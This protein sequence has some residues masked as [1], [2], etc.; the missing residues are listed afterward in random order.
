MIRSK[1]FISYA[2]EDKAYME[3]F[4]VTLKPL[5]HEEVSVWIDKEQIAAGDYWRAKIEEGLQDCSAA[6]LLISHAFNV[7]SFIQDCELLYLKQ[8]HQKRRLPLFPVHIEETLAGL[9]W[10][11]EIEGLAFDTPLK[12]LAED[13]LNS[14]VVDICH[15]IVSQLGQ[16]VK[17]PANETENIIQKVSQALVNRKEL[18]IGPYQAGGEYSIVC[19]GKHCGNTA[20]IKIFVDHAMDKHVPDYQKAIQDRMLL[21]NHC[22]IKVLDLVEAN[23][24]NSQYQVLI[25]KFSDEPTLASV[26][27]QGPFPIDLVITLIRRA[28]VALHELHHLNSKYNKF[29]VLSTRNVYLDQQNQRLRFSAFGLSSFLSVHARWQDYFA[30]FEDTTVYFTPEQMEGGEY[31]EKSDQYMLGQLAFELLEGKFPV[32]IRFPA[33]VLKK[34]RFSRNPEEFVKGTWTTR[35]PQLAKTIFRMLHPDPKKRWAT[36]SEV[37]E[38]LDSL[39]SESLSIARNSYE[40]KLQGI[41]LKLKDNARFFE[42]FYNNFFHLSPTSRTKFQHIGRGQEARLMQAMVD[43]FFFIRTNQGE[44]EDTPLSRYMEAHRN[45]GITKA[46]IA[47]FVKSFNLTLRELEFAGEHEFIADAWDVVLREV[48]EHLESTWIS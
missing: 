3:R 44:S 32:E 5:T 10:L 17:R 40:G 37:A 12:Q 45:R 8:A 1:I 34:D 9:T 28:A 33:D 27:K 21:E 26:L 15:A 30:L 13:K 41:T 20:A 43:V 38:R 47:A 46:E 11:G 48:A 22:F 4:R 25:A 36:M 24:K 35:H 39:D 18:E 14:A 2:H 19:K 16:E 7:S 23:V 6:I 29:G 42:R 31:T